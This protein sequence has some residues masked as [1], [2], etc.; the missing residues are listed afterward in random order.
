MITSHFSLSS[1]LGRIFFIII[2]DIPLNSPS[3]FIFV[4]V[5][6]KIERYCSSSILIVIVYCIV[7]VL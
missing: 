4:R 5:G 3:K 7:F 2:L 1:Y 6:S